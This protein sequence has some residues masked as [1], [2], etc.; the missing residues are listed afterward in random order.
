MEKKLPHQVVCGAPN[1]AQGQ[2][3]AFAQVGAR[4][5]DARSGKLSAL[6]AAKIRGVDSRGMVCSERELGLGDDHDGILVLPSNAPVGM[7]LDDYLGDVILDL[8]PTPNRSDWLSVLGVAYEVAA[9]TGSEVR[10]PEA[11]Y[12]EEGREIRNLLSVSIQDADLCPRYTASLI[13]GIAVGP[14]PQWLQKR[15]EQCDVRPINNVVDVTNYVMLEYGQPLHA[16]DYEN[17]APSAH[18]RAP[19]LYRRDDDHP[20]RN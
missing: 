15:L 13:R 20:G 16:F 4:L 7:A 5:V 12:P 6:K 10:Q 14:S 17:A 3:I 2:K 1:V 11:I 18:S 9:L 19:G 8:E